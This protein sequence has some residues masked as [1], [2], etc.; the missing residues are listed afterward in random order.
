MKRIK[1]IMLF[2]L[3]VCGIVMVGCNKTSESSEEGITS[4][5][6]ETSSSTSEKETFSITYVTN[7][8]TL[9]SR[10]TTGLTEN[11]DVTSKLLKPE[12]TGHDFVGWF[13]DEALEKEFNGIMPG[14]NILL[15]A[16]Y[17]AKEMN[18]S[19]F[20]YSDLVED[21]TLPVQYGT[22]PE[23]VPPTRTNA[24]FDGWYYENTY[25]TPFDSTL[26][27]S[28]GISL[29]ARWQFERGTTVH[30]SANGS[31]SNPGTESKPLDIYSAFYFAGP[32]V[33][34]SL[35]NET[36]N[37]NRRTILSVLASGK[38]NNMVTIEG[39]GA[40]LDF[41]SLGT[42][43][44]NRG[45]QINGDFFH[46]KNLTVQKAGDNG[47]LIGGSNNIVENC[48]F[49]ENKDTGL[50]ISR[51]SSD[52]VDMSTWPTNNL[53]LNCT[54]FNN[55]DA[56]GE[57]ADGFAAKLTCG[58][59]IFDGCIAYSNS[60]DGYDLYA[61]NDTGPI[62]S[63][64]IRNCVAFNNGLLTDQA[65][66]AAGDGNGF[67]LG[68]SNISGHVVIEN[69]AAWNNQAHGFTDNSN[70][71]TIIMKNC[72][73]INN[74]VADGAKDNFN[75][76]RNNA[77]A[78]NCYYGLLSYMSNS[79]SK[80][81][82]DDIRGATAYSIMR[83]TFGRATSY[84]KFDSYY[85][86][87]SYYDNAAGTQIADLEA[88]IFASIT[89]PNV[90][91]DLHSLLRNADGSMNMGDFLKVRDATLLTYCEGA[92]IG[93][94]LSLSS[95]ANYK[96]WNYYQNEDMAEVNPDDAASVALNTAYVSLFAPYVEKGVYKNF[97]LPF[98]ANNGIKITWTSSNS[99]AI[100]TSGSLYSNTAVITRSAVDKEVVLTAILTYT[101][102]D[103]T[104]K[105]AEKKFT[106]VVKALSPNIG[107][108]EGVYDQVVYAGDS[109]VD[110]G[111]LVTVVDLND[112]KSE[113]LVY[114]EHYTVSSTYKDSKG[115]L[116]DEIT[117]AGVYTV[118]MRIQLIG[119]E[120]YQEVEYKITYLNGLTNSKITDF[121]ANYIIDHKVS[122]TGEV[123]CA[124]STIIVV[125]VPKGTT[126][127]PMDVYSNQL[128]S[129]Y[130]R[131]AVELNSIKFDFDLDLPKSV[132]E[133]D[134][135]ALIV[136]TDKMVSGTA[137]ILLLANSMKTSL[138]VSSMISIS[139]TEEFYKMATTQDETPKAYALTSDLDFTGFTWTAAND[140]YYF[141]GY[142]EGNG[143][144]IRNLHITSGSL[145]GIFVN[146]KGGIVKNLII[147]ESSSTQTGS[148]GTKG[149]GMLAGYV[150]GSTIENVKLYNVNVTGYEGVGGLV[151]T[152]NSGTNIISQCSITNTEN[153]S[154]NFN[155]R[156]SGG[157]IGGILEDDGAS[158]NILTNIEVRTNITS[159]SGTI[160]GGIV[161]RFKN[162]RTA[163]SLTIKNALYVGTLTA[164][165][166]CGGA[167]G[168][169]DKA[170]AYATL[171]NVVVSVE[172][173][174]SHTDN[175]SLLGNSNSDDYSNTSNVISI[176]NYEKGKD[177]CESNFSSASILQVSDWF[178]S[179]AGFDSDYWVRNANEIY[180]TL[181]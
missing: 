27:I 12:K 10:I 80:A 20:V 171:T 108:I 95:N 8:G 177:N 146:I 119:Y 111:P 160:A 58:N 156:Y 145:P 135:H 165:K 74:G 85:E 35:K 84:A 112:P 178:F 43:D 168:S 38:Y 49:K 67:K 115:N 94:N 17:K 68:G 109:I 36:Y 116:V 33:T 110:E 28:S 137:T 101:N 78:N 37:L 169:I 1:G 141:S 123:D 181:K 75:M 31:P 104:T 50:Q 91:T 159:S 88:S 86:A 19:I 5:T 66:S 149:A 150:N 76:A 173:G 14:N 62:G 21:Y 113:A 105:T 170:S 130:V 140:K 69:C 147:R 153:Y 92:Q 174:V 59:N 148:P 154:I 162:D 128:P 97:K 158:T 125:A 55:S 118:V 77:K 3:I 53:V 25:V 16:K 87:N 138:S 61:K 39:N 129:A 103:G 9:G 96:N 47:V 44:S 70:P 32:G 48:V 99:S 18:V 114:N 164:T 133:C 126:V 89:A 81:N 56:T 41:A 176:G 98:E 22:T 124:E 179:I 24:K 144:E 90:T 26:S 82:G 166:Y 127:K 34:I 172:F 63:I 121:N 30:V 51:F 139:T 7:G 79:S 117:E 2:L 102:A 46:V 155:H 60:D 29:Y 57:N 65:G 100:D 45:I 132:T 40:I 143:H 152:V 161:G 136:R 120:I 15:Y 13:E 175:R 163:G 151:G 134:I 11:E 73:S 180:V 72:T 157:I 23:L 52:Q 107:K 71:G 83:F 142:L 131:K 64:I 93:A 6:E 42:G 106:F 122:V 4:T 167:I 54:S